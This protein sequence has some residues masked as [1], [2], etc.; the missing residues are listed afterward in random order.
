MAFDRSLRQSLVAQIIVSSEH[1]IVG[2]YAALHCRLKTASAFGS[3]DCAR[4]LHFA[5]RRHPSCVGGWP[6]HFAFGYKLSLTASQVPL[7]TRNLRLL[8]RAANDGLLRSLLQSHGCHTSSHVPPTHRGAAAYVSRPRQPSYIVCDADYT[9]RGRVDLS[10]PANGKGMIARPTRECGDC[11]LYEHSLRQSLASSYIAKPEHFWPRLRCASHRLKTATVSGAIDCALHKLRLQTIFGG[12]SL[13]NTDTSGKPTVSARF[14]SAAN[15]AT[16]ACYSGSSMSG[17][18]APSCTRREPTISTFLPPIEEVALAIQSVGFLYNSSATHSPPQAPMGGATLHWLHCGRRPTA[19]VS[20]ERPTAHGT[21]GSAHCLSASPRQ[22]DC[23]STSYATPLCAV[24]SKPPTLLW[25]SHLRFA[26]H[27]HHRPSPHSTSASR[28]SGAVAKVNFHEWKF[29]L[30]G[31][32]LTAHW[33]GAALHIAAGRERT[34]TKAIRGRWG[35][36]LQTAVKGEPL[37]KP[38]NGWLT[39]V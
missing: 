4:R 34:R 37:N 8:F 19:Y 15:P 5:F 18:R 25:L 11:R 3:I 13:A 35:G 12:Y 31:S 23:R 29:D 17:R 6:L 20:F 16:S 30:H 33:V 21:E 22:R 10:P 7:S 28:D 36:S 39:A 24:H 27:R 38:R 9:P 14:R 32:D 26:P 2:D 1:F